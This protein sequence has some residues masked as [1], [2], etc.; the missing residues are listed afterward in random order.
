MAR[1]GVSRYR[2]G[3]TSRYSTV[4]IILHWTIAVLIITNLVIGLRLDAMPI[5][6]KFNAMQLHKSIGITVLLLS[7]ARLAWRLTHKAPPY[8]DDMKT[9]EKFLA[10][11]T[12]WGFYALMFA[13]PL[14]GWIMVSASP[15]NIP[16]LLYKTIPFP[17][18]PFVH[19]LPMPERK[20]IGDNADFSHFVLTRIA[21]GLI[22]LH[23]AG[24]LK[25]TIISKD[26]VLYHMIP[27]KIFRARNQRHG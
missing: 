4:A 12:H 1:G 15:T 24:A 17:H 20:S 11:V 25:H 16:T 8:P 9:W 26:G 14:T 10:G 23:V 18:L 6:V 2:Y 19:D 3:M 22:L 27:L 21:M 13:L 5:M 7:V